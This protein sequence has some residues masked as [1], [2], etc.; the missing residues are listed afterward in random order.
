MPD[1]RRRRIRPGKQAV[2]MPESTG[3]NTYFDEAWK[4]VIERFFPQFLLFF[5]PNLHKDVDFSQPFTFLDKEMQEVAK[6]GLKGAKFV[7]KLVKIYLK[8]GTEQW[9]LVHIEVQGEADRDFS[10]RMFRYFNRIFERYGKPI[11]S[12]AVVTGPAN[13]KPSRTYE[14]KYYGSGVEFQYLLFRLTDFDRDKLLADDNPIALVVLAAQDA[15]RH[16][17][18]SQER[19]DVKWRLIR[20]LYRRNYTREEINGLFEFVDWVLQLSDN[21]EERL[22]QDINKMEEVNQMPYITSV[23]R[24]GIRKGFEQRRQEGAQQAFQLAILETLDERFGDIP[25]A[26]SEDILQI[27]DHDQLRVLQRQ[28]IRSASIED[29]RQQLH[30]QTSG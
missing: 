2:N 5:A 26:I 12:M 22:W 4:K 29:F 18:R 27:E 7:D 19:Y 23:E 17:R 24:I 1:F 25:S 20:I 28:V 11:V 3:Y 14:L 9:L 16:R 6:E 10:L 21:D 30:N 15:E 13:W 8:D